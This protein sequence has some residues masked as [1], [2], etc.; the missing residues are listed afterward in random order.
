[1]NV[2]YVENF[3][4]GYNA[5]TQFLSDNS[6]GQKHF[7]FLVVNRR[8]AARTIYESLR[9]LWSTAENNTGILKSARAEQNKTSRRSELLMLTIRMDSEVVL[10]RYLYVE[11]ATG[12]Y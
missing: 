10:V 2:T 12:Y 5:K 3:A 8:L 4:S 9:L 1:M 6:S 11:D 7:Q